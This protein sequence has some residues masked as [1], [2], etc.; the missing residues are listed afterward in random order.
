VDYNPC[1]A[2]N[3]KWP[4]VVDKVPVEELRE[5]KIGEVEVHFALQA[6]FLK[7]VKNHNKLRYWAYFITL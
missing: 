1:P 4:G 6:C 5:L 3:K 2:G 7:M